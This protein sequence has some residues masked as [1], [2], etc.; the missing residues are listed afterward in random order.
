MFNFYLGLGLLMLFAS[1]GVYLV[2]KYGQSVILAYILVGILIG[3]HLVFSVAGMKYTGIISD[4]SLI[5]RILEFGLIF[6]FFFVGLEFSI[7]KLK[8]TKK[9]ATIIAITHVS[10]NL[11]IGFIIATIFHWDLIGSIFLAGL[12]ATSS[13]AIAIKTLKDLNRLSGNEVK[14]LLTSI[15]VED[16][17]LIIMIALA[18][19]SAMRG[20]NL[21][22]W[23]IVKLVASVCFLY[24]IFL[25]LG[26]IIV[27]RVYKYLEKIQSDELFIL[28]ALAL[29]FLACALAELLGIPRPLGAFFMGMTFAETKF[30]TRL[31]QKLAAVRQASTA[32]FFIS[33][34]MMISLDT[35]VI[36][37][38]IP[39]VI[40]TV[41]LIFFN[42]LFIHSSVAYLIGFTPREAVT[43]G[44]GL[45]GRGE[46]SLLYASVGANLQ[47]VDNHEYAFSKD[48]RSTMFSFAGVYCFI[49]ATLAPVI[50]RN[51]PTIVD[52]FS[53]FVPKKWAFG[54]NLIHR[55]L[56]TKMFTHGG[57][58]EPGEKALLAL[59]GGYLVMFFGIII[60]RDPV[61]FVI[62]VI[63]G[64]LVIYLLSGAIATYLG[65]SITIDLYSDMDMLIK[66]EAILR[67]FIVDNLV[68][69]VAAPLLIASIWG[70][71]QILSDYIGIYFWFLVGAG[72]LVII[73][74]IAMS[75]ESIYE[76]TVTRPKNVNIGRD[77][78][79]LAPN[80]KKNRPKETPQVNSRPSSR[81]GPAS[82]DELVPM[83]NIV[84]GKDDDDDQDWPKGARR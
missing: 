73:G 6:L 37:I 17:I 3:P 23:S 41:P 5:S 82:F 75:C 45:S 27:P 18:S 51:I 49:M 38:V 53:S 59:F 35:N 63:G 15:I 33:F 39:M 9:A 81:I 30:S 79:R 43:I 54:S 66:D 22:L 46:D 8:D 13:A 2:S 42:H 44:A 57:P 14:F 52:R 83:K 26:F 7:T 1:I 68:K 40:I 65:P 32:F 10:A 60:F 4:E 21:D 84:A 28:F 25:L 34:G 20:T 69:L 12:I 16:F 76:Y 74:S 78:K 61:L 62:F 50:V 72:A 80:V 55:T 31:V 58:T 29:I 64:A 48:V 56:R 24:G 36:S 67:S 19:G 77:L 70:I 47:R 71:T 11:F